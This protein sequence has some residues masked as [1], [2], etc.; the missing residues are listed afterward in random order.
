M[1][2]HIFVLGTSISGLG[3]GIVSASLGN[4]LKSF[5]Y[6]VSIQKFDPYFN[7]TASSLNPL[8]H[9]EIFIFADGT[10][11]DQDLGYYYRF[12][13][14]ELTQDNSL[15]SGIIYNNILQNERQ[16]KYLG[17]TVQMIPH[18]TNEVK[19]YINIF[20]NSYDIVIHELGGTLGDLESAVYTEAIRQMQYDLAPH[21]ILIILLI[22]L[23]FLHT[24]QE[25]KTKIAQQGV[26][27]C[28]SLG[29]NPDILICRSECNFDDSI[30]DKLALFTNIKKKFIIKNLDAPSIYHVPKMLIEEGILSALK[31]KLKMEFIDDSNYQQWNN[32]VLNSY[33]K[34]VNIALVG[35]YVQLHDAYISICE[36]LRFAGWK[37]KVNVNIQWINAEEFNIDDLNIADGILVPGGFG[38]RGFEGKIK[39]LKYGRENNIPCLGICFGCQAMFVEFAR[40]VLN[41]S[42]ANSEEIIMETKQESNNLIVHLMDGQR[43]LDEMS[44]TLRLG[45]YPC[46][47]NID[48]KVYS[49]YKKEIINI[50]HRHRFEF[51]NDYRQRF[52]DNGFKIVGTSNY[53]KAAENNDELVELVELDNNDFYIGIQGHPELLSTPMNSE[54]LF[55]AFV[56]AAVKYH[57]K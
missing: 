30:K 9:G 13:N 43:N 33:E 46:K 35:K 22:Y 4:I 5:N 32:V 10:E 20:N 6:K 15:T 19:R 44:H 7:Y 21:N 41:I 34:T 3:K 17:Q 26:E 8:Q 27:K 49:F 45:D 12:L 29:I 53:Y 16:G 48:S 14:Q 54:P 36:A 18:I 51:N 2:K 52:N 40:N 56:H 24:T 11:G 25:I 1:T 42:D 28:R 39:A 50:R 38:F 23:P 37:N 57:Y 31:S 47:L 55:D